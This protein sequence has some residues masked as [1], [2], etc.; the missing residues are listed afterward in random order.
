MFDRNSLQDFWKESF[1]ISCEKRER[2]GEEIEGL[3]EGGRRA[4]RY[5]GRRRE[6]GRRGWREREVEGEGEGEVG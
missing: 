4:G 2:S 1:E 3:K 6:G 5:K